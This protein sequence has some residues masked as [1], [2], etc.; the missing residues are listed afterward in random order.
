MKNAAL[1]GGPLPGDPAAAAADI[2][3]GEDLDFDRWQSL[4]LP[5]AL[6][7]SCAAC[8]ALL[9]PLP[10]SPLVSHI[11]S[12]AA[13]GALGVGVLEFCPC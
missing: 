12:C 9:L 8:G 6:C 7:T 11:P 4:G 13:C 10:G 5:M 3:R 2:S 1:E